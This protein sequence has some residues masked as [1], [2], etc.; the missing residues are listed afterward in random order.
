MRGSL[1]A[2]LL[3]IVLW[4]FRLA[5]ESPFSY[6]PFFY[7]LVQ[8][9]PKKKPTKKKPCQIK[10]LTFCQKQQFLKSKT[11]LNTVVVNLSAKRLIALQSVDYIY[12]ESST[13]HYGHILF[14]NIVENYSAIQR[15]GSR[16]GDAQ[17]WF[18]QKKKL[19]KPTGPMKGAKPGPRHMV[20]VERRL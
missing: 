20:S 11:S 14:L 1:L 15:A 17:G 3:E 10:L 8:S 6:V 16:R 13:P 7:S 4:A 2:A 18:V 5:E 9:L 19:P 12:Y